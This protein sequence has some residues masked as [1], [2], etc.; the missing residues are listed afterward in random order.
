MLVN[1]LTLPGTIDQYAFFPKKKREEKKRSGLTVYIVNSLVLKFKY[2]LY[3]YSV[4]S[5]E[6]FM[7]RHCQLHMPPHRKFENSLAFCNQP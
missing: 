6:R 4:V 1:Y 2:S 3:Y 7:L 5:M